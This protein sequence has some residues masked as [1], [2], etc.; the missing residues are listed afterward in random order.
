[1]SL[2]LPAHSSHLIRVVLRI[3]VLSGNIFATSPAEFNCDM[4]SRVSG[5]ALSMPAGRSARENVFC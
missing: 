4:S 3:D 5:T 2:H 1:M